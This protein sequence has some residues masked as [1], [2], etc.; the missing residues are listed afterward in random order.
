MSESV[1]ERK[2]KNL[3]PTDRLAKIARIV[4]AA[5]ARGGGYVILT[6]AEIFGIYLLATAVPEKFKLGVTP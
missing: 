3:T 2:L 4:E 6:T 5:E 1:S